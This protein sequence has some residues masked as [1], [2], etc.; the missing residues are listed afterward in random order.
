MKCTC[1]ADKIHNEC[2]SIRVDS[3]RKIF[4][5]QTNYK[6]KDGQMTSRPLDGVSLLLDREEYVPS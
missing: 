3:G 5:K 6:R 2:V 4:P 1:P